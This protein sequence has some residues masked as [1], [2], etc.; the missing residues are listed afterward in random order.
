MGEA[1]PY[2]ADSTY[3]ER[4]G[5]FSPNG[6]WIAYDSNETGQSEVY[7]RPFPD[8]SGG[9]WLIST[10]GGTYPL[11]SRDGRE[12]YYLSPDGSLMAVQL[13]AG[14]DTIAHGTPVALFQ[15]RIR[16]D[17]VPVLPYDVSGD[18]RF[19]MTVLGEEAPVSPITLIQNWN[20]EA[21]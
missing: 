18:G 14:G 16:P 5:Q 4:F 9:I 2:L 13:D 15:T 17:S 21:Q 6:R 20:P 1:S 12:L 10:D 8:P 3:T 11:W 7:I 19:L